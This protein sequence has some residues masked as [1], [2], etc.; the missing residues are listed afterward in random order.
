MV[1]SRVAGPMTEDSVRAVSSGGLVPR[2]CEGATHGR[3]SIEFRPSYVKAR[4]LGEVFEI[5]FLRPVR[6]VCVSPEAGF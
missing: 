1:L 5:L 2:G 6:S 3:F 4:T